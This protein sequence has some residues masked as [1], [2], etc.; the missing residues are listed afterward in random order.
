MVTPRIGK[1]VA[2]MLLI[3]LSA[4]AS[5]PQTEVSSPAADAQAPAADAIPITVNHN[6]MD[7]GELTIYIEPAGGIRTVLGL[8]NT[9]EMKTFQYRVVGNRN[10]RLAAVGATS[11]SMTTPA[12]TVP[13]GQGVNW[14]LG[15]N[16]VRLR[17]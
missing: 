12:I 3:A 2:S 6:K 15:L 9:N 11:G 1:A 10:V 14:D 16:T 4:C 17:R 8:I 5:R 7:Q 13:E